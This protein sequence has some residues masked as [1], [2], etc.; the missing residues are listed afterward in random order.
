MLGKPPKKQADL[1]RPLL[2]DFINPNHRLAL[3]AKKIDWQYFEDEFSGLYSD[4]GRPAMPIRFMVGIHILKHLYNYG[5]ETIVEAWISNPYFQYF[6]GEAFFQHRFPCDPSDF[7]HFR[8]RIG[9]KGIKKIFLQ[10][11][12]L[13]HSKDRKSNYELSEPPFRK[14]TLLFPPMPSCAKK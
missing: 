2:T 11:V 14:T 5:D 10:S 7:V 9:E 12:K 8:K 13:H 3:L 1:F 4:K 6:C